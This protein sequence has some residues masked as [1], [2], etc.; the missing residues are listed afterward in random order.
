MIRFTVT[1]I[2]IAAL[3]TILSGPS[4][5]QA[6]R[7]PCTQT[8]L[9][10]QPLFGY[11]RIYI[12]DETGHRVIDPR[13]DKYHWGAWTWV[14][15]TQESSGW[16]DGYTPPD[17]PN[18]VTGIRFYRD[19]SRRTM[20]ITHVAFRHVVPAANSNG[21]RLVNSPDHIPFK[22]DPPLVIGLYSSPK[23]AVTAV[24]PAD[25]MKWV[26]AD[27]WKPLLTS[28]YYW[29]SPGGP[30]VGGGEGPN[31]PPSECWALT[32]GSDGW[33]Q[34]GCSMGTP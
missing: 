34:H 3:L 15:W 9:C 18:L 14:V 4:P 2:T 13:D 31:M 26:D 30:G 1:A 21:Y 19:M 32:R 25:E 28:G 29:Y 20:S 23:Q 24:V 27:W 7:I 33:Y 8:N 12:L 16:G 11:A 5:A 17:S 22:V 10:G 6:Q